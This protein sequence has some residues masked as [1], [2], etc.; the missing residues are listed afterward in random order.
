ME[1]EDTSVR[2]EELEARLRTRLE[3]IE[4]QI[5]PLRSEAVKLRAQLD[6][7]TK[8]LH[9]T[10]ANGT[11]ADDSPPR[12]ALSASVITGKTVADAV[13][14]VLA[15]AGQALH[16]S[17]IREAYL[18]TGRTIPG[19]GTYAN[20]LAYMIRDPRFERV[21]KGTYALSGASAVPAG[22]TK[23]RRRRRRK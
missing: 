23:R 4:E 21:A 1:L 3:E 20:L 14:E 15:G 12:V 16:I 9:I 11:P 2:I 8:L 18:Q 5:R 19:K 10:K 6:L 17:E 7:V 13:A 22:Y